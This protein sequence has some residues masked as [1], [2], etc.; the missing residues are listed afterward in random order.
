MILDTR[1]NIYNV[2]RYRTIITLNRAARACATPIFSTAGLFSRIADV[3]LPDELM[4]SCFAEWMG[5]QPALRASRHS[6]TT[7]VQRS[8]L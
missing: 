4:V 3:I 2:G 6:Q 5:V 7:R 1:L 8:S